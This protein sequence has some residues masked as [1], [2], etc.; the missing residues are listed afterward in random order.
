M[1]PFP[2]GHQVSRVAQE[3][4]AC[5]SHQSTQTV[6]YPLPPHAVAALWGQLL[7]TEPLPRA[8]R[9]PLGPSWA[10]GI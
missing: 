4:P 10:A 3:M 2:R 1:E 5:L 7:R 6:N 8:G 9:K